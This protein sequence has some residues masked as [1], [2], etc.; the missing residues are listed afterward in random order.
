MVGIYPGL[1]C[2]VDVRQLL[3]LIMF[4]FELPLSAPVTLLLFVAVCICIVA[5][6]L[7]WV[8]PYTFFQ[9]A[10]WHSLCGI[11]FQT[12]II[13]TIGMRNESALKYLSTGCV[14]MIWN[15]CRCRRISN[16]LFEIYTDKWV[17]SRASPSYS[18]FG[19]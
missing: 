12:I 8:I 7:K 13:D 3:I 16:E 6:S 4:R 1:K 14:C 10:N 9:S 19:C 17:K 15:I 11:K 18:I 5:A 2:Y